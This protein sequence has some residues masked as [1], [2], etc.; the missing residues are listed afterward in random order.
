VDRIV[1][2]VENFDR[3]IEDQA[4]SV[5]QTTS[6]IEEMASSIRSLSDRAVGLGRAFADLSVTSDEGQEQ[7]FSILEKVGT[8]SAQSDRLAEANDTVK[9]IAGQTNLLSMNAAIEAA[10]A[11]DAGAGFAVVAEEIRKLADQTGIHSRAITDEVTAIR[12]LIVQAAQESEG[13]KRA[14]GA[15]VGRIEELGRFQAEL[16]AALAEQGLGARQILEA[17]NRMSRVSTEVR[18]GSTQILEGT[19]VIDREISVVVELGA[20]MQTNLH[21]ILGDGTGIAGASAEVLAQSA[22]N[23]DLST[24]LAETVAVFRL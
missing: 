19:K 5:A 18:A 2:Q 14:F 9:D 4:A 13:A 3:L 20:K 7:L 16:T 24:R 8:I 1:G 21:G 15:I 22:Q 23:R 17:T 12:N 6:S 11:G 10:H